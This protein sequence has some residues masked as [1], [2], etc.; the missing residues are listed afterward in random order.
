[1]E[2]S[3]LTAIL[4]SDEHKQ[5]MLLYYLGEA[6]V[7]NLIVLLTLF[8]LNRLFPHWNLS[9]EVGLGISIIVFI[10]YVA[11][12]YM[13]SGMDYANV[14]TETSFKLERKKILLRSMTFI[15]LYL[16]VYMIFIGFPRSAGQWSEILG[17]VLL[18]GFIYSISSYI[19]LK[20]SYDKNRSL[21]DEECG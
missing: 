7:L 4:P 13:F 5:K 20:R 9:V 10:F 18:I 11:S 15:S 1:M 2:K 21:L 17:L 3:W 6:A 14:T 19:S 12:R 16:L 8:F